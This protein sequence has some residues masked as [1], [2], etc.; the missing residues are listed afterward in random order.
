M[1]NAIVFGALRSGST[2]LRLMLDEHSEFSCTG[3]HDYLFDYLNWDASGWRYDLEALAKDRIFLSQG[4][5]FPVADTANA[6]LSQLLDQISAQGGTRISVLMLHRNFDKAISF[7]PNAS[8]VH[9]VRDPRDVARSCVGMGWYGNSYCAVE[10]WIEAETQWRSVSGKQDRQ[11]IELRY[12]TLVADPEGQLGRVCGLLGVSYEPS[13]LSYPEHSTY[14]APDPGFTEQWRR[15]MTAREQRLVEA[16]LG[17]LLGESGYAPSG[18]P[19]LSV[20]SIRDSLLRGRNAFDKHMYDFRQYGLVHVQHV[21]GRKLA[22]SSLENS[23][24]KLKDKILT[25]NYLR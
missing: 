14:N 10:H 9:L 23:A 4:L 16:R 2:M 24:R 12:E 22:I 11:T 13:M 1:T 5:E 15:K 18:Q 19:P 8:V 17:P 3:E 21:L 25:E 7:L 6:V 20:N